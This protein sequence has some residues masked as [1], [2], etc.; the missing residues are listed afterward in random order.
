MLRKLSDIFLKVNNNVPI[1]DNNNCETIS[2]KI[3]NC[4]H[5][6]ID[7]NYD[8]LNRVGKYYQDMT[9]ERLERLLLLKSK[10][11]NDQLINKSI[12][13]LLLLR[14]IRAKGKC[15]VCDSYVEIMYL[16]Q[17]SHAILY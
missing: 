2:P 4:N 11:P 1:T 9:C 13:F 16:Q 12:D 6:W 5:E 10:N 3:T 8:E 15:L 17:G 14:K 7:Y